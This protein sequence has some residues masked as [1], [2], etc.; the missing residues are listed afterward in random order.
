M[1]ILTRFL[2]SLSVSVSDSISNH[3][4]KIR[5][6][7]RTLHPFLELAEALMLRRARHASGLDAEGSASDSGSDSDS[8]SS[9]VE[10]GDE[11]EDENENDSKEA[12]AKAAR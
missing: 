12:K 2:T 11:D 8:S 7:P 5:L 3:H 4:D 10:G 1:H 9:K 6:I